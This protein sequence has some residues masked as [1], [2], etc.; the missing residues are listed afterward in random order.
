M[1][2]RDA[3]ELSKRLFA[4]RALLLGAAQAGAFA[5]IAGR[6]YQLQLMEG[7]KFGPLA[8]ENRVSQR[9]LIPRRGRI[10][11]RRGRVIAANRESF[12]VAILPGDR[13]RMRRSLTTLARVVALPDADIE[14]ILAK[15]K[16][17]PR[18]RP[19]AVRS[20]LTFEEAARIALLAPQLAGVEVESDHGRI[21]PFGRATGHVVG[22]VGS[23]DRP[24]LDDDPFLKLPGVRVGKTGVELGMDRELR[25]GAGTQKYEVDAHGRTVRHLGDTEPVPGKDVVVTIDARLQERVFAR[26]GGEPR[27]AVVALDVRSGEVVVLASVPA[28]DPGDL[29]VNFEEAAF[30]RLRSDPHKP[31][32]NRAIAGLYPPGSTFK[33]VTALAALE[34]G[35]VT[36]DETVSCSGAFHFA[37][38]TYRCWRHDGHGRVDLAAAIRE[39]CDVFFYDLAER[40]GVDRIASMARRLGLGETYACGIGGQK[41]GLIP[42]TG[43]KRAVLGKGWLRGETILAGIGQGYVLA[44]PL[45]LAVMTARLATGRAVVPTFVRTPGS[46]LPD[47]PVFPPLDIPSQGLEAVRRAMVGVVN[48]AGGTGG[49]ASLAGSLDGGAVIIAGKTGTS[50][51]RTRSETDRERGEDAWE[52]RDHALFVSYFPAHAPR[53]AVSTVVEHGGGGGATAAPIVRDVIAM[54]LADDPVARA[55]WQGDPLQ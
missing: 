36:L 30:E 20:G 46:V 16:G 13:S 10:L 38:Q 19:I 51:V 53:Y 33:M 50:Q 4:R 32:L 12:R 37:D 39:S 22:H 40:I 31:M 54:L 42:T 9:G 34:A 43:W 18:L 23:V 2:G 35:K 5:L 45:Q 27:A 6:L 1:G 55:D 25:G 49:N 7:R 28:F 24:A 21:Y 11:D 17:A 52:H 44:T 48:E 14:R 41:D 26:L 8:E 29:T 3:E 47:G 15:A